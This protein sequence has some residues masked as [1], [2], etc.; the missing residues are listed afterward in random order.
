VT[1]LPDA[2]SVVWCSG[3]AGVLVRRT[4]GTVQKVRQAGRHRR[5]R[6]LTVAAYQVEKDGRAWREPEP[7]ASAMRLARSLATPHEMEFKEADPI[8]RVILRPYRGKTAFVLL[9]WQDDAFRHDDRWQRDWYAYAFIMIEYKRGA[10]RPRR[11]W[12]FSGRDFSTPAR[13]DQAT[14]DVVRGLLDFIT[15]KPGD[16]DADYFKNY[17]Q[18]Q[19]DFCDQHAEA[20]QLEVMNRFPTA[21]E[22]R[23]NKNH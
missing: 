19:L 5:A 6:T 14:D 21:S 11:R 15:L 16:T 22:K 9:L 10:R 20:V 3:L 4:G 13:S 8:R 1:R 18:E 7:L 12:L 23:E 17:T 2:P